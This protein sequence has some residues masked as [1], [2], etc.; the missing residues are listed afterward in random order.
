M[1]NFCPGIDLCRKF[2]KT[3]ESV[4]PEPQLGD[5]LLMGGGLLG[6]YVKSNQV[7]FIFE[8]HFVV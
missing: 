7:F 5:V 2:A 1:K 8:S 6:G 4:I 3:Y